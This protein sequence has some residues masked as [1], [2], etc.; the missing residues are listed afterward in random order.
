MNR[1]RTGAAVAL[2]ALALALLWWLSDDAI[3]PGPAPVA[4][5]PDAPAPTARPTLGAPPP[6]TA[7]AARAELVAEAAAEHEAL[8]A[9][10]A[11]LEADPNVQVVCDV[12]PPL[13]VAAGYLAI[14]GHSDGN[15]RVVE[16]VLGK[17]YL[18]LVKLDPNDPRT[19]YEGWLT[20]EGFGPAKVRFGGATADGPGRCHDAPIQLTSGETVVTGTVTHQGD[21][22]PAKNAW[23]EGCGSL[24]HT[25]DD[26]H[27]F[28][29]VVAEPC[30]MRA[31]RQDGMLR[32]VSDAVEITPVAGQD[33]LVNFTLPG[34]PRAGLGVKVSMVEGG[35]RID[36]VIPG[37]GAEEAG[38]TAGDVVVALDGQ[39]TEDLPMQE[40]VDL[41]GGQAG[42]PLVVTVSN[43]AGTRE[44][45]VIRRELG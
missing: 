14:D 17:A 7:A 19:D 3:A 6:G 9:R 24:A 2:G 37:G 8:L 26:G 4:Q 38:L 22:K 45:T 27:Y 21:G 13:P 16:V 41:V 35:V 11:E 40:F 1:R 10:R 42:S 20:I 34:Y 31:M 29:E 12:A 30:S 44:L 28:M 33:A 23:V 32:T 5:T 25:D 18:P 39:P 15:G 43:G 36:E